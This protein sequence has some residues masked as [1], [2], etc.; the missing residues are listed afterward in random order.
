VSELHLLSATEAS[1]RLAAGEITSERLVTDCLARIAARDGAVHAWCHLEEGRA[2]AAARAADA[3]APRSALHGIPVGVKDIC[4]TADMPTTYGSRVYAGHRPGKDAACVQRLRDLGA[5]VLGK[6]VTTEF[7]YFTPGPTTNPHHAG[8]TPGGSSSGSAA[9]VADRMCPL[10]FGTQT[11]GSVIRPAA[12][13]GVVGFKGSY[14]W[15]SLEGVSPLAPELDTLGLFVRSVADAILFHS[16]LL[17]TRPA[18][19]PAKPRI[20]LA[21]S[22]LWEECEA[23]GRAA[24][25]RAACC[26]AE[27]GAV[28]K[29]VE[30]PFDEGTLNADQA[31]VMA[32]GA[33]RALGVVYDAHRTR[34]ERIAELIEAGRRVMSGAYEVARTRREAARAAMMAFFADYDVILTPAARGEA[35]AGLA[36]TGDPLFNRAWTW[37]G[38][39]CMALPFEKGPHGLPLAVQLVGQP[40][41][42]AALLAL[43]RWVETRLA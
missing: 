39:P 13:C 28:V 43:A 30:L 8:H 23:S 33:A 21:R 34:L 10:A 12:F 38:L 17:G 7:A 37:L 32:A 5:I 27:A 41:R 3:T 1:Q 24:M 6:T 20:A 16:T 2:L 42:D 36:S 22:R 26:L 35:P 11:A 40:E 18:E 31:L 25:E 9:A 29:D 15:Y 14:G 4:D 19:P